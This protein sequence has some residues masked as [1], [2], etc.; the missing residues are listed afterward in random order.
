M[1]HT[2]LALQHSTQRVA[3]LH[4]LPAHMLTKRTS[5]LLCECA[6]SV[7][8]PSSVSPPAGDDAPL[9]TLRRLWVWA[10]APL[11][12][13]RLMAC[14]V[15]TATGM[16]GGGL[17]GAVYMH[18]VH[19]DPFVSAFAGG[20]VERICVPFMDMIRCV[21]GVGGVVIVVA[22][23]VAVA[24]CCCYGCGYHDACVRSV[25]SDLHVWPCRQRLVGVSH[26]FLVTTFRCMGAACICAC[27]EA[28]SLTAS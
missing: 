2:R 3:E 18:S 13:L 16:R 19:G 9:L 17:A 22:V 25:W 8:P 10:Q 4:V 24:C 15:D 12:R 14:I 26:G 1:P 27:T 21:C 23:V 7:L 20:V 6:G 11:Q 5:C 28:G